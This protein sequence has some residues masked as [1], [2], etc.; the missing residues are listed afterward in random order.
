M[1]KSIK[2]RETLQ[3]QLYKI[4]TYN[5]FLNTIKNFGL[6]KTDLYKH[7]IISK[8][9]YYEFNKIFKGKENSKE[10]WKDFKK[11][12]E[13]FYYIIIMNTDIAFLNKEEK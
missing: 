6:K 11:I 7:G 5:S 1:E 12:Y 9:R 13:A 4:E 8:N 10:Q 2:D 3:Q